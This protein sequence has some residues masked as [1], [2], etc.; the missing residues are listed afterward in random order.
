M[1]GISCVFDDWGPVILFEEW[2]CQ[3][4][5]HEEAKDVIVQISSSP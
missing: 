4:C 3:K 5:I 1:R 2:R